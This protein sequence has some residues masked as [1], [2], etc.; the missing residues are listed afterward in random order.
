MGKPES[1]RDVRKPSRGS[2]SE[3]ENRLR[4]ALPILNSPSNQVVTLCPREHDNEDCQGGSAAL[5][6]KHI[7]IG[8]LAYRRHSLAGSWIFPFRRWLDPSS[9]D[10]HRTM[11]LSYNRICEEVQQFKA[12]SRERFF[13]VLSDRGLLSSR[14]SRPHSACLPRAQTCRCS[15]PHPNPSTPPFLPSSL[16]SLTSISRPAL[17]RPSLIAGNAG[18][19]VDLAIFKHWAGAALLLRSVDEEELERFGRSASH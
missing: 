3:R 8:L 10:D 13:K 17:G 12:C 9:P 5:D 4:E 1:Y 19:E 16:H 15:H 7:S 2:D 18:D 6:P 11:C 14:Q